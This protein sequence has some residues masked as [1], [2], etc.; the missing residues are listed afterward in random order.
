V[1]ATTTIDRA[2]RLALAGQGLHA[3]RPGTVDV[4]HLRRALGRNHVVQLDSVSVAARAHEMPFW[5]RLGGHDRARRDDWL[6][7]GRENVELR[8]HE[9]CVVPVEL[10]PLFS[11]D[12]RD[13]HDW[14][15]VRRLR[16]DRPGYVEAVYEQV[17]ERGPLTV[18]DL[19]DG[20]GERGA[21][22]W[23]WSPGRTA[24]AW[25]AH[26]GRVVQLR[27]E[28]FRITFDLAE[29]V[30]PV[31]VLEAPEP[32]RRAARRQLLLLA[33]RAHGIG[34]AHD[35]A[36]HWR[37][38]VT[39]ARPVLDELAAE[40]A[41]VP[42]RVTGVDDLWY[43]HPDVPMPREVTGARLLSPFDPLVWFRPRLERL[44]DFDYRIEIYVPRDQRRWGYYVLPFLL[45]GELVARVDLKADR[46]AR[47]LRIPAAWVEDGHDPIRVAR[48][49]AVELHRH[50]AWQDL[51]EVAVGPD[52]D[53]AAAL[54]DSV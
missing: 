19:D 49:L 38:S 37:M 53:L 22:M 6:W 13:E 41:L 16:R 44:W 1:T 36:D 33:A 35:L 32:P 54:A 12:R 50:A 2:R 24:L 27:D 11:H 40:G 28:Q 34:T 31:E 10:W 48:E 20:G 26:R 15:G 17:A 43:R 5:S 29:R 42:T 8:A 47:V 46:D 30:L 39:D 23:G 7:D 3:P 21:G 51:T 4:R 45:D 9:Q 52:G 14:A 18:A 25:L